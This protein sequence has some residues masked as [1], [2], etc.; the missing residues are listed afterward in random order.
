[1]ICTATAT[2]LGFVWGDLARCNAVR[3][4]RGV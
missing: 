1:M 3:A 4:A 2:L